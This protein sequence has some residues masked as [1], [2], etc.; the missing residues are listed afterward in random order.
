MASHSG[1]L[2]RKPQGKGSMCSG[3]AGSTAGKRWPALGGPTVPLQEREVE[4]GR[5]IIY[6]WQQ[7]NHVSSL[8][9]VHGSLQ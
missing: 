2:R 9:L 5:A 1:P 7:L 4:E 6:P 8:C 3:A